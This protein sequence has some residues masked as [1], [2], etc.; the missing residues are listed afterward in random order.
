MRGPVPMRIWLRTSC[1]HRTKSSGMILAQQWQTVQRDPGSERTAEPPQPGRVVITAE[2][3]HT[4]A[5]TAIVAVR[6]TPHPHQHTR[7]L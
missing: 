1:P 6:V 4:Q 3:M 2:A 5:D 7:P